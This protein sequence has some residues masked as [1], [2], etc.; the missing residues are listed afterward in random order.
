MNIEGFVLIG[1]RSTRF[2]SPKSQAIFQGS[3]L[4][5]HAAETLRKGLCLEKIT[6]AAAGKAEE[7]GVSLA[8]VIADIIPGKGSW[9]AI[10][11][12]LY[13][14]TSEFVYVLACDLPFVTPE[15]VSFIAGSVGG[16]DA[17]VARQ[18]DGR[19]QPLCAV[20]RRETCLPFVEE[21]IHG[22]ERPPPLMALFERLS[23][24][25]VEPGEY[26]TLPD[27]ELFF[28][29]INTRADLDQAN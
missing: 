5:E 4:A 17:A 14:S 10:H 27:S 18:L 16:Y 13:H 25:I 7:G 6:F 2:G 19:L 15:F 9:S 21:V 20:Y 8:P 23:A 12:A 29:N 1:G 22:S 3:T 11:S 24:R 28:V 26:D